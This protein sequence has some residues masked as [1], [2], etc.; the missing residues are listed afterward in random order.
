MRTKLLSADITDVARLQHLVG[1]YRPPVAAVLAGLSVSS[2]GPAKAG[3]WLATVLACEA[4]TWFC[5]RPAMTRALT[6]REMVGYVVSGAVTMPA[7][8]T[9]G[10]MFW[11][12]PQ[13]TGSAVAM[14]LWVGQLLYTQRFVFQSY[15]AVLLGNVVMIATMLVVP[16]LHPVLAGSEQILF[17]V[18]LVFCIAFTVSA[19]LAAYERVRSLADQ[20]AAIAHA[21]ITDELTGLPNRARFARALEAAVGDQ[22]P[23][24]VLYMDLDRFKL[25]N[26]TLG[27]QAGDALLRQF[28][29]RL[30]QVSP[31]GA[32]VARL[33]GDEFAALIQ[34]EGF[35]LEDAE[36]L[37]RAIL[38]AVMAPFAVA[39][40]QAHVG[41]SIGVARMAAG[42][43]TVDDLMRRSDIALYTMKATGRAGFRV[44]SDDL[45]LEVR[46]RADI[47]NGLRETLVAGDGLSLA[48]QPKVGR[49]GRIK[50]VEALL[51]WRMAGLPVSPAIFVPIAEETGLILALGEW[52]LQEALG[53]A[54]RW[55][56]LS[57]AINLSPA[58]LRD[59]SFATR[60]LDRITDLRLDP[61]RIELEVTETTLF[62]ATSYA[63][64]ALH[65]L[66]AAGL[67]VALDDFGTGYSS[68]RHLHS[69]SVD[70]VKIDQTF[71]A[72]LGRTV[73]SGAI[74][75]A[76]I[77]LGHSMGLQI[78]AEGVETGFQRDFLIEA[79]CDELQGYFFARP[80]A[81]QELESMLSG[82]DMPLAA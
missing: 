60:L 70:R 21:A 32:V 24:C 31:P 42:T 54:C 57:V 39:N 49:D 41:V 22:A 46:S 2:I 1:R 69:V 9:L 16:M 4:W 74:I 13:A 82:A 73:E 35:T 40:G 28:G 77:Q 62:E 47:E 65:D 80:L 79:G 27:H 81:E 63:L 5:T 36:T 67:H 29:G 58:Q 23:T 61:D 45:E 48:Y 51:R 43:A 25:V 66:R 8:A 11:Y 20:N 53:F 15:L 50:G 56:R 18:G 17:E 72:G 3:A 59:A 78:T 14:A 26:D 34:A 37:C 75:S 38:A 33:G 30:L 44:F 76:V 7:W 10:V 55:P 71:V 68:L 19:S 6:A 12:V 52:V 64:G